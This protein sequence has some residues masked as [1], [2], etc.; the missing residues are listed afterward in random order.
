MEVNT[1]TFFGL[2]VWDQIGKDLE[3][4]IVD[5]MKKSYFQSQRFWC[6]P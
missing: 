5:D 6:T 2:E 4:F 1:D 3:K